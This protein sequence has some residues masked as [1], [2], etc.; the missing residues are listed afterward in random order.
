MAVG[1][2]KGD[3]YLEVLSA[4]YDTGFHLWLNQGDG[5]LRADS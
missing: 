5:R 3:G 1:D 2:F 4:A